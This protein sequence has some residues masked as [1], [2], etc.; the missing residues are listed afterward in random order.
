MD[1]TTDK[2]M[3]DLRA[4][5]SD[6]ESLLKATAGQSG[7]QIEKARAHAEASLRAARETLQGLGGQL[8]EQVRENPWA[9]VGIAAAVGLLLGVLLAR[10]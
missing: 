1:V 7:E 4:V 8:D 5:V 2:L 3:Q 10:K 9:A 6:A